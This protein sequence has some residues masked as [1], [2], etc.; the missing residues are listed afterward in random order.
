MREIVGKGSPFE[1]M[2]AGF[3]SVRNRKDVSAKYRDSREG[4]LNCELTVF[5][6]IDRD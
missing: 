2:S 1:H 6:V 4:K 3:P 5:I